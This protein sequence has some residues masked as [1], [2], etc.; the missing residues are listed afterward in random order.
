MRGEEMI[1]PELLY[2]EEGFLESL[3][4][5]ELP[6]MDVYPVEKDDRVVYY[7]GEHLRKYYI[8]KHGYDILRCESNGIP[9][10]VLLDGKWHEWKQEVLDDLKNSRRSVF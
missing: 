5:V 4:Y 8:K 6:P 1:K 3:D 2:R 10:Y 7:T 9:D